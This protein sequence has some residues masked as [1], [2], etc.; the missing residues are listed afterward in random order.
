MTR[1]VIKVNYLY[2]S[3]ISERSTDLSETTLTTHLI[4]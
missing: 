3:I 1:L 4:F 2:I